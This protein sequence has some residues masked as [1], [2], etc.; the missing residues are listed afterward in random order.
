MFTMEED[1][2]TGT[3]R[4]CLRESGRMHCATVQNITEAYAAKEAFSRALAKG[5]L[6]IMKWDPVNCSWDGGHPA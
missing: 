2:E 6:S 3:M 1:K 5:Q 4:V